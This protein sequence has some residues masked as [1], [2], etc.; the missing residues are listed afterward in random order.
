MNSLHTDPLTKI[1]GDIAQPVRALNG[2]NLNVEEG[3][4]LAIM[5][6]SGSGKS[7][8]LYLLGGLESPTSGKILLRNTDLSTMND[9]ALSEMRR[10][11]IGFIFQFFNLIPVLT[12]R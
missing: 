11:Q 10:K 1:Y 4:F 6:P 3:E 12:A 5:G 7:T 9:D 8:L 2:V